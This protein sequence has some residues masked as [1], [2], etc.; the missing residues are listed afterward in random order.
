MVTIQ[1]VLA[2]LSF[3]YKGLSYTICYIS[4]STSNTTE[5]K[6]ITP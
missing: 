3:T 5:E 4:L 6:D 1:Y 2:E